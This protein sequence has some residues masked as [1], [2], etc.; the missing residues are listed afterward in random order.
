MMTERTIATARS[1]H[2]NV[3]T[4]PASGPPL[5]LLHGVTREWQDYVSLL[6][7][8]TL[9]WQVHALDFRG[10]G[11]SGRT[12]GAYRVADY[13]ADAAALLRDLD[14]PAVVYGHS[15]GAMVVAA[16]A[17]AEPKRGRAVVME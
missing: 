17:G 9:R 4:G 15:L 16:V 7:A 6:P 2:L 10:H 12:P 14:E 11:K 13:V 8:L 5:V 3:A 1:V